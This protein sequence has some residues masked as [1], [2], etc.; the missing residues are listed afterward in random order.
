MYQSIL[1]ANTDPMV[2]GNSVRY[3]PSVVDEDAKNRI[4]N[5]PEGPAVEGQDAEAQAGEVESQVTEG[6]A[7]TNVGEQ[8]NALGD[9]QQAEQ[10][11][12]TQN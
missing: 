5:P 1:D 7:D 2:D 9:T 10:V 4:D 8:D 3:D 12:D 11:G 6:D